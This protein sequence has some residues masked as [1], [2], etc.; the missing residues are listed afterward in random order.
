MS[1]SPLTPVT[2]YQSML[3]RIFWFT[4]AS[5]LVGVWMLRLDIPRLD[6]LLNAN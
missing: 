3:N 5:A 4:T 6:A 1:L 2:D